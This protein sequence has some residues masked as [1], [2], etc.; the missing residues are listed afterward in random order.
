MDGNPIRKCR[1]RTP[2]LEFATLEI[3]VQDGKAMS[4]D[5]RVAMT[6]TNE[7]HVMDS[8]RRTAGWRTFKRQ[9]S[10]IFD[11]GLSV[12]PIE[13]QLDNTRYCNY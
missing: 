6:Q 9:D 1:P 10:F 3:I 4:G 11:T 8:Y 7:Q 2:A 5:V 13:E 12:E